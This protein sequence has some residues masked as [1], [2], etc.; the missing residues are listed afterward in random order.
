[1]K[2]KAVF[3]DRDGTI[4]EEM[5]YINHISRFAVFPFAAK[6]V[7]ILNQS[8]YKVFIVSN[9]SGV[10]RGYFPYEM[11]EK[12]NLKLRKNFSQE[13][14]RIDGIYYCPYHPSGI[15]EEFT[16]KSNCRKPATGM[17]D[18]IVENF[19]IDISKSFVIGD[20]YSDIQL[21]ANCGAKSILVL[22]GY[23]IGEYELS[24]D[25]WKIKPD[26]IASN[27]LE[28]SSWIYTQKFR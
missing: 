1:M 28:A 20:R 10:A 9:Q 18:K 22:T 13:G 5:G 8:G 21:A 7:K 24:Y 11:L 16:R 19:D 26:K 23:G 4:N 15:V 6:A 25:N 14:A 2:E 3:L 12:I 27:L 17:I